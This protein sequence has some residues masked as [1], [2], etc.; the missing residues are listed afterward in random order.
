MSVIKAISYPRVVFH[1]IQHIGIYIYSIFTIILIIN[2]TKHIQNIT[3]TKIYIIS[4][5]RTFTTDYSHRLHSNV[6]LPYWIFMDFYAILNLFRDHQLF[7]CWCYLEWWLRSGVKSNS[8]Y[9]A[10][11][12]TLQITLYIWAHTKYHTQKN[13]YHKSTQNIHYRL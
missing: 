12:A 6:C 5:H 4:P 10:I 9:S 8:N 3:H 11:L 2:K 13:I 7:C 1:V